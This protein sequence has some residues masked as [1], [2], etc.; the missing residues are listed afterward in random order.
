MKISEINAPTF[1][2]RL[3]YVFISKNG[4]ELCLDWY[5]KELKK[6]IGGIEENYPRKEFEK[7][8]KTYCRRSVI[9]KK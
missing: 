8:W 5:M 3:F 6:K 1:R 7:Y 2:L 9:N 4:I